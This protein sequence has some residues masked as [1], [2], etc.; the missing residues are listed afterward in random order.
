MIR[1]E[2]P[3]HLRLLAGVDGE[4]CLELE[5]LPTIRAVLAELELRFP[6]LN[7]TIWD[8]ASGQRRPFIRFFVCSQDWSHDRLDTEL[9]AEVRAG[10]E[11]LLI[12]GAVAGG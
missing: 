6:A 8:K 3:Y 2:L 9:P 12:V 4:V 5:G 11:P 1:V 10:V 7:G